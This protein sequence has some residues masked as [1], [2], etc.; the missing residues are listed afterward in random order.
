MAPS[1][2][3]RRKFENAGLH[4]LCASTG[5]AERETFNASPSSPVTAFFGAGMDFDGESDCAG[6]VVNSDHSRKLVVILSEAKD[7]CTLPPVAQV[8]RGKERRSG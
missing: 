2:V 6:G 4:W 3:S 7:L 1:K 8:L 5:G